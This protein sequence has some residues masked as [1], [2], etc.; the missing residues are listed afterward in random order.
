MRNE[1]SCW[2]SNKKCKWVEITFFKCH[3]SAKKNTWIALNVCSIDKS[4]CLFLSIHLLLLIN[5]IIVM[6]SCIFYRY[7]TLLWT[8]LNDPDL[9]F[10]CKSTYCLL[11]VY[12]LKKDHDKSQLILI[13]KCINLSFIYFAIILIVLTFSSVSAVCLQIVCWHFHG[14]VW[15][16]KLL[17]SCYSLHYKNS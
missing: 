1:C 6:I 14:K 16:G 2:Y 17:R 9:S 10:N 3:F 15:S 13:W 12:T 4:Y 7:G 8:M 11:R 5:Q